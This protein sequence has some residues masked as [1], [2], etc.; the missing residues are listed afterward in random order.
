[1]KTAPFVRLFDKLA[2]IVGV[3][4]LI[5]TTYILG[6][7]PHRGYYNYHTFAVISLVLLRLYNYRKKGW[8]YYLFDFCYYASI[9]IIVYL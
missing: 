8:H 3:L 7:Y 6:R 2:F 9:I 1:M 4:L 5:F